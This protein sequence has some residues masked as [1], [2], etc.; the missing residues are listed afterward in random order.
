MSKRTRLI[1]E[2]NDAYDSLGDGEI[3]LLSNSVENLCNKLSKVEVYIQQSAHA[4]KNRKRVRELSE[5]TW[6]HANDIRDSQCNAL[7][8]TLLH[9]QP[10]DGLPPGHL[11]PT[12]DAQPHRLDI[13]KT[14]GELFAGCGGFAQAAHI[15]GAKVS[16]FAENNVEA[17]QVYLQCKWATSEHLV[18]DDGDVN[19]IETLPYVHMLTAGPPCTQHSTLGKIK[20]FDNER[21]GCL[22]FETIRLINSSKPDCALIENVANFASTT[23]KGVSCLK[24]VE[25]AMNRIGWHVA[26]HIINSLQVGVP[27][28]RNRLYLACFRRKGHYEKY[29]NLLDDSTSPLRRAL[30]RIDTGIR[31]IL[32]PNVSTMS[33]PDLFVSPAKLK[34]KSWSNRKYSVYTMDSNAPV[35]CL[36]AGYA[37]DGFNSTYICRVTKKDLGIPS[38][39]SG[40]LNSSQ[41]GNIG[42]W[43]FTDQELHKIMGYPQT[44]AWV[45]G[46]KNHRSRLLGNSI[47]PPVVAPI[48]MNMYEAI[49]FPRD[50]TYDENWSTSNTH[51]VDDTQDTYFSH[52][53]KDQFGVDI[54]VFKSHDD[55]RHKE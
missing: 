20:G 16:Y 52:F 49:G 2:L 21:I 54:H 22:V 38:S 11:A 34:K 50:T 10:G 3:P 19:T 25:C 42:I 26:P 43:K 51:R 24:L 47:V 27:Q 28:S 9:S 6:K 46:R 23:Y 29:L 14:I 5:T 12:E 17:R 53:T 48:M 37:N 40:L 32:E 8:D 39:H 31:D 55:P 30:R 33:H 7:V 41:Y 44:L 36:T 13:A 1:S 35:G 45:N 4:K 18:G 15:C